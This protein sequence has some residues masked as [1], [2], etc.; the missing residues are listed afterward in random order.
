MN[1]QTMTHT[2]ILE[3]AAMLSGMSMVGDMVSEKHIVNARNQYLGIK[4]KTKLARLV[5]RSNVLRRSA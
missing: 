1:T 5:S 4:Y 2:E 3:Y